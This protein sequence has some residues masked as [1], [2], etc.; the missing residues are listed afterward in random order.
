MGGVMTENSIIPY[1][2]QCDVIMHVYNT[3]PY[4]TLTAT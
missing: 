1:V 3:L 4:K 2:G